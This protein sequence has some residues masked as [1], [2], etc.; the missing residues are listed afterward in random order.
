[1]SS[2]DIY[3]INT[4]NNTIV[5]VYQYV[6]PVFYGLS[7]VGNLLI[8]LVFSRKSWKKN[9]CVFYFK[10]CLFY[11]SCYINSTIIGLI[12]TTGF[13]INLQNSN[14][15]LCKMY[16]YVSFLLS[17][18]LPTVVILASIDRLLISSQNIDRRLYRGTCLRV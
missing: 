8:A 11:N 18:L 12:F 7:N 3:Y 17:T 15:I 14:I 5:Y 16:F 6:L 2:S 13:K 4:L 10:I 1:M 9:V